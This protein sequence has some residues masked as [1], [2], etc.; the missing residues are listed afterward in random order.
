MTC[1]KDTKSK[2]R[3]SAKRAAGVAISVFL[4]LGTFIASASAEERRDDHRGGDYR[5]NHDHGG[6]GGGY[7]R[8]PPVVYGSP[9]YYPPPVVYG[10]AIGIALPGITIGIR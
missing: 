4:V 1:T 5:G 8:A 9:A 2:R 7:Y 6:P 10:P 3:L